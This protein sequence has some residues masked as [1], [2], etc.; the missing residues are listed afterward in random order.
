MKYEVIS[1][2]MTLVSCQCWKTD[3]IVSEIHC[4]LKCCLS[5]QAVSHFLEL[6]QTPSKAK[7]CWFQMHRRSGNVNRGAPARSRGRSLHDLSYRSTQLLLFVTHIF[8]GVGRSVFSITDCIADSR[9]QLL[10]RATR[11]WRR[12]T[13][14]T[15]C[16]LKSVRTANFSRNALS[17]THKHIST[18]VNF[19]QH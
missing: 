11:W 9:Y 1:S 15:S 8:A 10:D 7:K 4:L 16:R 17:N 3:N 5:K 19:Q 13:E 2:T 18:F 6:M 14:L 12:R